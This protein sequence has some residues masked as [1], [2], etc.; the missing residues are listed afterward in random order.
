MKLSFKLKRSNKNFQSIVNLQNDMQPILDKIVYNI[1][2]ELRSTTKINFPSLLVTKLEASKP[3]S[4]QK[5]VDCV[6]RYL[7]K[8]DL[9]KYSVFFNK[10]VS[11]NVLQSI[12]AN[13]QFIDEI[14]LSYRT[15]KIVF[16][17]FRNSTFQYIDIV[18]KAIKVFTLLEY[19]KIENQH[20]YVY[21]AP[22]DIVKKLPSN[23]VFDVDNI[24][25]GATIRIHNI[26]YIT[27]FRY[28]ESDKVLLHEMIHYLKL[29]FALSTVYHK[30]SYNL[31]K[32]LTDTYNISL[33][34]K[35]INVF[36]AYTD[37][38]A[39]VLN[40]VFNSILMKKNVNDYFY[41]ELLYVSSMAFRIL[42]H[43]G[44][45]NVEEITDDASNTILV[46]KTSV[47]SYYILKYGLL[48]NIDTILDMFFPIYSDEWTEKKILEIVD[49]GLTNIRSIKN[50][51]LLQLNSLRMTYNSIIY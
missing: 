42:L 2:T 44:F 29:D 17:L 48:A 5:Y 24:N 25:S 37:T 40:S 34:V 20:I 3:I 18:I 49:L 46:Q 45:K 23:N 8:K 10:F 30:L 41:T 26:K 6:K 27:L 4:N 11:L 12:L 38:I 31:N 32:M 50:Y 33:D 28:E 47:F 39:I 19:L 9:Q 16:K 13:H 35:F 51:N 7:R 15:N 36:E 14:L 1:S 22:V 21:Y 43:A